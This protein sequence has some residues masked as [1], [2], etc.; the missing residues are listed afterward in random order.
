MSNSIF[1][2]FFLGTLSYEHL[3]PWRGK[4]I[5]RE[6]ASGLSKSESEPLAFTYMGKCVPEPEVR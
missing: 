4:F 2:C 5:L 6:R 1:K 3:R